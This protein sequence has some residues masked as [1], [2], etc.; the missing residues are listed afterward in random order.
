MTDLTPADGRGA[1]VLV[2]DEDPHVTEL[3]LSTLRFAG[4]DASSA[5]DGETAMRRVD[6]F[7]PELI[8]VEVLLPGID[9]FELVR[10]LRRRGRRLPVLF[11]T[12]RDAV[13]DRV[14]GLL[15]G[16]DDYV[17]KPFSTMELIARV[18]ALLRRSRFSVTEDDLL[19]CA[20][21][22]INVGSHDVRRAGRHVEL[23]PTEYRLLHFLMVNAGRV[24]PKAMILDRVWRYDFGGDASVVEK[25]M[26]TL[27]RKI[28]FV[29]PPLLQTVRGFGYVLRSP[30]T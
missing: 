2:V 8:V 12:T 13:E 24:V 28:D 15:V 19:V 14:T 20:D 16:G 23:S 30:S 7:D 6:D 10:R 18:Y 21:L 27:R 5:A 17:L 22:C 9:G 26:S 29:D 25:F 4:H 1:R 3:L 11:L